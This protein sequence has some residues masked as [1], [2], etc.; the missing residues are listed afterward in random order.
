MQTLYWGPLLRGRCL[1]RLGRTAEALG[2]LE[3]VLPWCESHASAGETSLLY[4]PL[5]LALLRGGQRERALE[6]AAK[7]L[8]LM[9][10]KRPVNAL[11][12]GGQCM[13]TE[14]FLTEWERVTGDPAAGTQALARAAREACTSLRAYTRAFSFAEPFSLLCD[15]QEAWLSGRTEVALRTWTRCAERAVELAMPY[16]EGRARLELGRHL[17]P[18][19]PERKAHLVRARELFQRLEAAVELTRAEAE[20][21]RTGNP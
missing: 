14:V 19:A 2:E 20:L 5:S 21:A 1:V 4:G 12:F 15:G 16:E 9:R 13:V 6:L 18:E 10:G 17:A 8:A 3:P 11:I 7:G